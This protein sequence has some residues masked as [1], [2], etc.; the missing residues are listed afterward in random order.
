MGRAVTEPIRVI[1]A[2]SGEIE[3]ADGKRGY[4]EFGGMRLEGFV[5]FEEADS[6]VP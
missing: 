1:D 2:D 6:C 5:E 4:L 3:T